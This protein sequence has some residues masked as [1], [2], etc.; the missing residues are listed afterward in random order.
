MTI[1]CLRQFGIKV[2][3]SEVLM[4]FEIPRQIYRPA[5]YVVEG[6]WSSASYLLA[7]GAVAG[8]VKVKNLNPESLQGD[9]M[10]PNFLK[11]M[12]ARVEV[13]R[14]SVEVRKSRLQAISAD[15]SDCI[16]LLPAMAVLAAIAEGTSEFVGISRARIKESNR[17]AALREGLQ[18]M[19]VEVKEE[20]DRLTI[21]GSR[22]KGAVIDSK[23]DHRIAMAF[24]VLGAA[25]G[26]MVITGAECVS[27]TYPEFWGVLKSLGGEVKI[28]GE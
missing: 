6:D 10:V 5:R 9:K 25:V 11:Q 1:D 2:K 19:G 7:L 24:G 20:G 16:D 14:D 28:D 3:P 23:G 27:K 21:I 12:G 17:V 22:P 26:D 18:K 4:K 13:N 8:E 15:L